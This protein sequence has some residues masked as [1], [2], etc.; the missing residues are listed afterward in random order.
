MSHDEPER[1]ALPTPRQWLN[2]NAGHGAFWARIAMIAGTASTLLLFV[3]A[4]AIAS[5]AQRMVIENAAFSSVI[6]PLCLLPLAFIGRGALAWL[7]TEAGTRSAIQIR[8]SI[9]RDLLGRLGE[10]GPLWARRQHS[11]AL[12]NRV[13]D[14]VD[15]LQGY[16]ADYRPQMIL[17]VSVPLLILLAVFPLNWAAGLILLA[18]APT[19][20]LN[21]AVVGMGAKSRQQAQFREMSRMSRHFLDTLRGLST[22]KLF[23]VS[24]R[25]ADE[26]H[27]ASESFRARTMHVLRL[28]FLSSAVLE[29]FSSVSIAL[30]ALYI[31]FTYLGQFHFGTWGHG[32][33]L[34]IGLFVL[35]L[36]PEFYQPLRDLGTHYHAKAEAEA[37]A[38]DLIPILARDVAT[39]QGRRDWPVPARLGLR[40]DDVTCR[41]TARSSPALAGVS[42]E[43]DPG[44]TLAVIGPSGAGKTTL[45]NVLMGFLPPESGT[46]TTDDGTRIDTLAP[47]AWQRA[48][49][50]VGQTPT[51]LSG[52]LADNLRLAAPEAGEDALWRA[53]EQADLGEWAG[54]LPQGLAT[55][56]GEGGQPVSGG[57][58]RRIA[59]ARA[60]LREAP[61][62]LLDEPTA[63]L[64][65][66]SEARVMRTL[67]RLRQ[68][69]TLVM[70]THRLELLQLAD[71]VLV[72]EEGRVR[73]LGT[74]A[75]LRA[76]GGPLAEYVLPEARVDA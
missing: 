43:I 58:A 74:L 12:G 3:Q 46:L 63:S 38:E 56:L 45:L 42:L 71:R 29:F 6:L 10:L 41:Y 55:R 76:D 9:R 65:R 18:T 75:A 33:D 54:R 19:I 51:L 68:G 52:S 31:G 49:G 72:L 60:F 11:A 44:E 73:A 16:Y 8:Q 22:L 1:S 69:R 34:F 28:A 2:A 40:L 35:I 32:L 50:W 13:W 47:E 70:L 66:D 24:R 39:R 15:A 14:Q 25:Q 20:P 23:G 67:E 57:Q 26:V 53:L 36:A 4:W 37:A 61:L 17:C 21:M 27:A 64:D 7:K 48:I 5:V 30:L 62:V 59:L